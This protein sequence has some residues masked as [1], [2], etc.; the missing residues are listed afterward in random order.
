[1]EL[2]RIER[3]LRQG[4]PS[5]PLYRP[6]AM[7]ELL[8]KDLRAARVGSPTFVRDA[9]RRPP[10]WALLRTVSAAA[11]VAVVVLAGVLALRSGGY[12]GVGGPSSPVPTPTAPPSPSPTDS[13]T[14]TA[15]A[16]PTPIQTPTP[17]TPR[18]APRESGPGS[19][20]P[21]RCAAQDLTLAVDTTEGAAGSR[22]IGATIT[23]DTSAGCDV[24]AELSA[25]IVDGANDAIVQSDPV[26]ADTGTLHLEAGG[27]IAGVLQWTNWCGDAPRRPLTLQVRID[28]GSGPA[29]VEAPVPADA[30][31]PLCNDPGAA[32][33]TMSPFRLTP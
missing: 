15:T 24:L 1:M 12:F 32:P 7:S 16:I 17:T 2:T 33:G 20:I 19:Q 18:A 25:Y 5:E 14:P 29:V 28:D 6:I 13:P 21:G 8:T 30:E 23:N 27:S 11:L 26:P 31:P 9:E 22:F 10:V 4:P 3:A